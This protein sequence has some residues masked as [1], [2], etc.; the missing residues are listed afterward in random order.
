MMIRRKARMAFYLVA[1]A[2]ALS[3]VGWALG[4]LPNLFSFCA[5]RNFAWT[6]PR[7]LA[8]GAQPSAA[9][10]A[11][12]RKAGF[13]SVVNL[14]Q[15]TPEY[16]EAAVVRALGMNYLLIAIV[17]DTAPSPAQVTEYMG[18]VVD[19]FSS[20]PV[21][22]HDAAGRGRMGFMDGVYL[23]WRGWPTARVFERYIE[24]GAKIDCENG[25][26]GQI[27]ALREIGIILGRGEAWPARKDHYR[28]SWN[29]C[30]RPDY[31]SQWDYSTVVFPPYSAAKS[32]TQTQH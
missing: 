12:F 3:I 16:D 4:P 5:V 26:N 25:G 9:S 2:G 19:H 29:N 21:L 1:L 17:D 18:F 28:N 30:P 10:L 24:F 31:M 23:L 13:G 15:E 32:A 11:C 27:Q 14:R 20:S 8:R 7:M 22:T 6:E